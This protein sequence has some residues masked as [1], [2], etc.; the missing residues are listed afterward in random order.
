MLKNPFQKGY[1]ENDSFFLPFDF[2]LYSLCLKIV[3]QVLATCVGNFHVRKHVKSIIKIYVFIFCIFGFLLK[4][5]CII[6]Y[7]CEKSPPPYKSS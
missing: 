2:L 7:A 4:Y 5:L 1:K 6:T 3:A